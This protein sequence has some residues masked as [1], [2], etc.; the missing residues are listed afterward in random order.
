MAIERIAT[1]EVAEPPDGMWSNCLR[2]GNTVYL[3]GITARD[4]ALHATRGRR[5]RAVVRDLPP[6]ALK[7]MH[8]SVSDDARRSAPAET[9]ARKTV[10]CTT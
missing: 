9:D 10:Q 1:P 6:A 4:G 2:A 5:V 8:T 3:S 7:P